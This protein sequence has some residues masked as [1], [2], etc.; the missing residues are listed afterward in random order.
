MGGSI[1]P[2]ARSVRE[3]VMRSVPESRA[4]RCD[5]GGEKRHERRG[6]DALHHETGEC[7][8]GACLSGHR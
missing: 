4:C 6:E 2:V 7:R 8:G 5:S 1:T 3:S